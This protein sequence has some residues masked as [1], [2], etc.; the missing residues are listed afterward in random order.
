VPELDATFWAVHSGL[1]REGPG[2]EASMSRALAVMTGL[3]AAPRIL[4]IGCGPGAQ[5]L[6]LA[7]R[8]HGTITAVDTHQDY[9]DALARAAAERGLAARITPTKASM[10]ALPFEDGSFDLIWSEGAAYLMGFERAMAA[11]R[12]LLAPGGYLAVSEACWLRPLDQVSA[13]ARESWAEYPAM[14]T[15]DGVLARVAA[16]GYRVLDQFVLPPSA[17]W[18]YY[19][20]MEARIATL[21]QARAADPAFLEAL[22][23]HQSEV[24]AYRRFG[25]EYSY[26]FVVAQA[27]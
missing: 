22:A 1:E 25:A 7:A 2:D 4:D 8:T 6:A 18:N 23:A 12:R 15:R 11:W 13:G 19:G 24:D 20:P 27:I 10:N 16:A 17:W 5:S 26:L 14:T 3:P 9:L 21:R